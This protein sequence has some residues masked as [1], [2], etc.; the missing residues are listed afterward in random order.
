MTTSRSES[1]SASSTL[2]LPKGPTRK[3]LKR[4]RHAD[5]VAVIR[6]VRGAVFARDRVCTICGGKRRRESLG[7]EDQM[8]EIVPRSKTRGMAPRE[9]FN[10][11]NCHRVCAACHQ[12]I[13]EHRIAVSRGLGG[14]L[15]VR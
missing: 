11:E 14:V 15:V 13:T 1:A 4:Q 8:N 10:L 9:R 6:E 3:A 2:A 5:E 7:L 12:D